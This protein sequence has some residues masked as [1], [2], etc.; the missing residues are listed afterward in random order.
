MLSA[1]PAAVER[2]KNSNRRL[3]LRDDFDGS[4]LDT[5]KRRDHTGP[6]VGPQP[7]AWDDW[8]FGATDADSWTAWQQWSRLRDGSNSLTGRREPGGQ[9]I[10]PEQ[11]WRV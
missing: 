11:A 7:K 10:I 3:E 2:L 1:A 4:A 9:S 6:V 5:S 8:Q